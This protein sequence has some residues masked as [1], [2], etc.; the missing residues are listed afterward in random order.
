[1]EAEIDPH[2]IRGSRGRE[3]CMQR[4]R[5]CLFLYINGIK[6][7]FLYKKNITCGFEE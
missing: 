6:N 2:R 1:M 4:V 5:T 3:G 7:L